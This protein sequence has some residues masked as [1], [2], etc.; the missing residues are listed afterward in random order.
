MMT[1]PHE[2]R[3]GKVPRVAARKRLSRD[4]LQSQLK[5]KR[6]DIER[7][8]Q[9]TR[10]QID[11]ANE[12]IEART[13][14]NLVLAIGIGLVLGVLLISSL[15]FLK[16]VFV[17]FAALIVAITTFELV[18]ALNKSGRR[19]DAI[20]QVVFGVGIV[21]SGYLGDGA[22]RWSALLGS[23]AVVVVWRLIAQMAS[24][25]SRSA[26]DTVADLATGAFVQ[27]YVP[28]LASFAVV[29]VRQEGGQWW[30]LAFLILVVSV[31][32]GAYVAGLNFGK[33]PMAPRISPKKTWEGFI[34]AGIAAVIAGVLL[35]L[36]ML[37]VEW[38]VGIILGLLILGTATMGDLTESLIK[39][40]MGVKDMSSW[41]PGHGG[42]LDRLDSMLPSAPIALAVFLIVNLQTS[43]G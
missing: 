42:I 34:G 6:A 22:V 40:D 12:R 35:A 19:I 28:F 2:P 5:A 11:Q 23:I 15:I 14:R 13:G 39:R 25:T 8:V 26:I 1:D 37:Q 27:I 16:W 43:L 31:D 9:A 7:Q 29:L 30:V 38:W 3:P 21:A 36:F 41:L 32:T 18:Q 20:P 24:Q 4:E 17:I 33:H 10:A